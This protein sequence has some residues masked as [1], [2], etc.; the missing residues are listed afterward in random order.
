MEIEK[1]LKKLEEI[2][3]KIENDKTSIDEAI[4]M[5][6]EGVSIIKNTQCQIDDAVGKITILKKD[7]DSLSEQ[8]FSTLDD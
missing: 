6:E 5:F 8:K 4:K 3:E 2:V 7:L 1:Q